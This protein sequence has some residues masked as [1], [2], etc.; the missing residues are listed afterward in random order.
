MKSVRAWSQ[1]VQNLFQ[2]YH[3][4][5]SA[6][7]ALV[8][9]KPEEAVTLFKKLGTSKS[10][11]VDIFRGFFKPIAQN[12]MP[13]LHDGLARAYQQ[14]GELDEA[15]EEYER[16]LNLTPRDGHLFM[17]HPLYHYRLGELYEQK[18]WNGKAIDEYEKFLDLWKDA[19]PSLTDVDDA[20]KRLAGLKN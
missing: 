3:E 10:L 15:I 17:I 6:E 20:K 7:A 19:D 2:Y 5:L 13:F 11:E 9:N 4:Y 14:T 18:G 8:N 16:I 1:D 12:R